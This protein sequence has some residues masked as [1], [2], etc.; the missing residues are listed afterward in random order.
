MNLNFLKTEVAP[1]PLQ[2]WAA[3]QEY[4]IENRVEA[5][6]RIFSDRRDR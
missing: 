3:R 4:V 5:S 1:I 2:A 6:N